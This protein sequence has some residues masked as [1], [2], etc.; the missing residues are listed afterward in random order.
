MPYNSDEGTGPEFTVW[1]HIQTGLDS[2]DSEL[3]AFGEDGRRS[4]DWLV[5]IIFEGR[6]N[7]VVTEKSLPGRFR[8]AD[9]DLHRIAWV[10]HAVDLDLANKSVEK[11]RRASKRLAELIPVVADKPLPQR[12]RRY[13]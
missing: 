6:E 9:E 11:G 1:N 10:R 13:V 7:L 12:A 3:A 5:G 2:A 8:L 4:L